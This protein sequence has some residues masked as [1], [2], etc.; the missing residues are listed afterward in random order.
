M[1][2]Q[3][4]A[5]RVSRLAARRLSTAARMASVSR[6][7]ALAM[8]LTVSFALGRHQPLV[9]VRAHFYTTQPYTAAYVTLRLY[10]ITLS[11][12]DVVPT[13]TCLPASTIKLQIWL[14]KVSSRC[15]SPLATKRTLM[16]SM[17]NTRY[18]TTHL[19]GTKA[20]SCTY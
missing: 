16:A 4:I 19:L 12:N 17:L 1:I 20:A 3:R 2:S 5:T 13:V 15:W 14:W 18:K 8:R 9:P 10:T 6:A 11:V 7:P